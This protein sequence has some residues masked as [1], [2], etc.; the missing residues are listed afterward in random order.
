M[1]NNINCFRDGRRPPGVFI[2]FGFFFAVCIYS[3]VS[4]I[5]GPGNICIFEKGKII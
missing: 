2:L 5:A 4:Q 1:I 3:Y